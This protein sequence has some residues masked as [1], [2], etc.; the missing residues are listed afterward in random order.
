[1]KPLYSPLKCWW[2]NTDSLQ[3]IFCCITLHVFPRKLTTLST[4]WH[5]HFEN[6]FVCFLWEAKDFFTLY[7]I[8]V[9][10]GKKVKKDSLGVLRTM[11]NW[12]VCNRSGIPSWLAS[13]M[14]K[15]NFLTHETAMVF[16]EYIEVHSSAFTV[17]YQFNSVLLR[18]PPA[19]LMPET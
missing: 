13:I 5:Q 14:T 18:C 4:V 9:T 19:H 16:D 15:K 17:M 1:M 2:G 7:L 3:W 10:E 11:L 8:S 6:Q 12:S